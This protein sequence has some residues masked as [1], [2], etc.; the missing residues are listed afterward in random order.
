MIPL[1]KAENIALIPWSPTAAGFLSGK[2]FVNG[3]LFT[4]EKDSSRVAP[5]S[6]S[7]RVYIGNRQNDEVVK[8][9][10]ELAKN[11]G[12][13]PAQIAISWI[14]KKGVTAPI[15]GTSKISH[16]EEFVESHNVKISDEEAKFLEEPYLPQ[17]VTGI[18]P[19]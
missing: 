6:L 7:Y 13:Q 5:G 10:L 2:Y 4:T 12:A 15:V 3:K 9:V 18:V 17:K 11:K 1:C 16:L 14:L 8:R 19:Q